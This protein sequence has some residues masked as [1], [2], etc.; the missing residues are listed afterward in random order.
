VYKLEQYYFTTDS[1]CHR[2]A[3][4]LSTYSETFL[5]STVYA[6]TLKLLLTHL[7]NIAIDQAAYAA[8]TAR[9]KT[10]LSKNPPI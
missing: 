9:G 4:H 2:K 1:H 6:S 10:M 7:N 3:G 5:P 8:P